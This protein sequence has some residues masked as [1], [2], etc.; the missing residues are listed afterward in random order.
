MLVGPECH[1]VRATRLPVTVGDGVG[2]LFQAIFLSP[3][4]FH[5]AANWE[6]TLVTEAEG[7]KRKEKEES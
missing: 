5:Y 3:V 7:N 4:S 2:G 1:E 6:Q